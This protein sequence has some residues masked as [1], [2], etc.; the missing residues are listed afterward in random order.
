MS[1][2]GLGIQVALKL[3]FN[4]RRIIQSPNSLKTI[5]FRRDTLNLASFLAGFSGLFRVRIV[6][7]NNNIICESRN[8]KQFSFEPFSRQLYVFYVEPQIK[9]DPRMPFQPD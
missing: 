9:I 1:C 6:V 8:R 5:L 2:I 7:F 4:M 3:V